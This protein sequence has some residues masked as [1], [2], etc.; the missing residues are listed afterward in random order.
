MLRGLLMS[1]EIREKKKDT[2]YIQQFKLLH[3]HILDRC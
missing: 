1:S 2:F 3:F